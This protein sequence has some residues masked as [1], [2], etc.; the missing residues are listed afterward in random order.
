MNFYTLKAFIEN[1]VQYNTSI[2]LQLCWIMGLHLEDRY[3]YLADDLLFA[4]KFKSVLAI[5][6]ITS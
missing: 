2:N 5:E 1:T 3:Y 4:W 6:V